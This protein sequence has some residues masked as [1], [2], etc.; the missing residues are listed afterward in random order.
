MLYQKILKRSCNIPTSFLL[1]HHH[2]E[3]MEE[4]SETEQKTAEKAQVN[5]GHRVD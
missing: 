5:H 2:R 1:S 3:S 4:K